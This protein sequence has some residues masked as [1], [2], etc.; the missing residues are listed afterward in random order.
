M[1]LPLALLLNLAAAEPLPEMVSE[2]LSQ[3]YQPR[4]TTVLVQAGQPAAVLCI[5]VRDD[6]AKLAP[7]VS[8]KLQRLLG[9]AVP[10]VA[11][12]DWRP[13]GRAAILFG[14]AFTG[15]VVRRL[16]A[17][18][19]VA[20]DGFNPQAGYELRTIPDALDF[21]VNLL[22]LGATSPE[23]LDGAI[24][25]LAGRL[26]PAANV[27]LGPVDVWHVPGIAPPTPPSDDAIAAAADKLD[28]LLHSFRSA[29]LEAA[30]SQLSG[31]ARDYYFT[32]DDA[33]GRLYGALLKPTVAY[34]AKS[35]SEPPT[36]VL[37]ELAMSLDQIDDSAGMTDDDRLRG[38][39]WLRGIVEQTMHFWEMRWPKR[40]YAN[41]TRGPIWNHETHPAL[42]LAHAAQ[43]LRA[44]Y[45]V[46]AAEYWSAVI[47]WLFSSQV[48]IDQPL[49][50]SANYQW[51]VHRH[52]AEYVLVTGKHPEFFTGS[53]FRQHL[54]YA[55][56]SHDSL[57]DEATHGDAWDAF[58]SVAGPTFAIAAATYGDP[59]YGFMLH[60][61]GRATE[62]GLWQY[63]GSL[64]SSEPAEQ[65]GLRT[66]L[67]DPE[68]VK[69]YD[70]QGVPPDQVL[71]KAVIRSGWDRNAEY[72]MLD[73][74]NVGNHKHCDAN[75]IIRYRR[76]RRL[77]LVD[78]D[79][80]RAAPK[81]HN[82]LEV[83]RDGLA[84]DQR[85]ASRDDAQV[86]AAQPFAAE[87]EASAGTR[88]AAVLRS[89]LPDYD[90]LD[91]H[92]TIY[93]AAGNGFLVVDDLQ[94]RTE[95]HYATRCTWR[96]L[97][98]VMS[99]GHVVE[100]TQAGDHR[101]G[102][103][104]LRVIDDAGRTVVEFTQQAGAVEFKQTLTAGTWG[105]S[106]LAKGR[107]GGSDSLFLQVGEVP[108]AAHHL[109]TDQYGDSGGDW[110]RLTPASSLD[111]PADGEYDCRIT[112]REN[113]GVKLD[114]VIL[115]DPA[116]HKTRLEAE[117]LVADQIEL[118]DEPEQHFFIVNGDGAQQTVTSQHDY[119]HGSPDGYYASYRY[120]DKLTRVVRQVHEGELKV[121]ER[122][123]YV[124][125][126]HVAPGQNAVVRE[127]RQVAPNAWVT[128]GPEPLL[129]VNGPVDLPGLKAKAK[130]LLLTPQHL[131]SDGFESLEL[132]GLT[133]KPGDTL[134]AD[135][136]RQRLNQLFA[137]A[138]PVPEPPTRHPLELPG[139]PTEKVLTR[140]AEVTALNVGGGLVVAGD[141]DGLVE[142][143][144]PSGVSRWQFKAD[145]A[146]RDVAP[147][148]AGATTLWA[149]G[150]AGGEVL[151]LR[152]DG[153][154]QWRYACP[155][156]HGR[157]GAVKTIFGAGLDGDGSD[158]VVAGS[159]DWH[160][161]ALARADGKLLWRTDTTHA[162]TVGCALDLD[163]DGKDEVLAGNEY[164]WPRLL[165]STGKLQQLPSGGPVTCVAGS[166]DLDGDGRPEAL[167]G[168]ED[169]FLRAYR[170]GGV[171]WAANV[172]GAP[173]GLV[174]YGDGDELRVAVASEG[175]GVAFLNA[176]G[177]VVSFTHLPLPARGITRCGNRL[178]VPCDDGSVYLMDLA[179][180]LLGEIALPAP[181]SKIVKLDATHAVV[182]AG[183]WLSVIVIEA[184]RDDQ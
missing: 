56:A 173:T 121:G 181:P 63:G 141:G 112:L 21:G 12:A 9:V 124:N 170:P 79:Y 36:F 28:T 134:E 22:Y 113:V 96:T 145:S 155:P 106:L 168:M 159:E 33:F 46:A 51:L 58:G 99:N 24:D 138:K 139:R 10:T 161:H 95:G 17:N 104:Q 82:S 153:T 49:E 76:Q 39:E 34:Y 169:S 166:G 53:A 38:A 57:G 19:L 98:N 183:Q 152:A 65:V 30:I 177:E 68:R 93:W 54:D 108:R 20:S 175:H 13:D 171:N 165:S 52:T 114:A 130:V 31:A 62:P 60:L 84:P 100:V 176:A 61:L 127:L 151:L 92:R 178:A 83:T 87:L 109:P 137:Q 132:G 164:Y 42:G 163:G 3:A 110:E 59:R 23:L 2:P 50:D 126:F 131:V 128:A 75:A 6:F 71:D 136:V 180:K 26:K 18:H 32:G 129:A 156:F 37:G 89:L 16:Y 103:E 80:I 91:W 107:D 69:A 150:T 11:E 29:K 8:A 97:G 64:G 142:A 41:Q 160:Y 154:E 77:W 55:I 125:W 85:P 90:G 72:L 73:G 94:A 66:F 123:Q 48:D 27:T 117:D 116:G 105:V 5:P 15:P 122:R 67:C 184:Q 172:G 140:P 147:I 146:I 144:T 44:H 7:A 4:P 135:A 182:A 119:G 25:D 81:H 102:N 143:L 88:D 158:E 74:L 86:I 35:K 148:R 70:I 179:G 111:V 157:P 133:L 120:A 43:Y 14:N 162:A 118:M 115:T 45:Q 167:F 149:V 47:D 78:M 101:R 1:L 40:E 174:V